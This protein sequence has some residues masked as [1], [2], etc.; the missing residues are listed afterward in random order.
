MKMLRYL[1]AC[2][3]GLLAGGIVVGLVEGVSS[4]LH[5]MPPGLDPKDGDAFREWVATLPTSAFLMLLVAWG[6]GCFTGAAL[7]RRLAPERSAIPAA[8]VCALQ[9][10]ATIFNLVWLPHP[11][12][13]W[14]AGILACLAGGCLGML[15]TAPP[16]SGRE[17]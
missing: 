2:L 9:T 4:R 10:A 3:A 11:G 6:A 8:I 12:W 13:M 17:R 14:P 15:L 7:A 1:G 5:P 16:K